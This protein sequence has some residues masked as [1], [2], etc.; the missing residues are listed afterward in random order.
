MLVCSTLIPF[1]TVL[2]KHVIQSMTK[3]VALKGERSRVLLYDL[4][5]RFQFVVSGSC[6]S[7]CVCM[8]VC[9]RVCV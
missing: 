5:S 9:V 8:C 6:T 1:A 7:M 3:Q 4:L 2:P